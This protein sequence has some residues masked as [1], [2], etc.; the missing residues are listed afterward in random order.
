[1][2]DDDIRYEA[3]LAAFEL[4]LSLLLAG[5][6]MQMPG[7]LEKMHEKLSGLVRDAAA[8]TGADMRLTE[9]TCEALDRLMGTAKAMK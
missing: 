2:N 9:A 4:T 8:N 6:A 1:M 5:A 7:V 3:R